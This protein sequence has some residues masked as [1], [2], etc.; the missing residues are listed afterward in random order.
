MEI[1][2]EAVTQLHQVKPVLS[3]P[4]VMPVVDNHKI[5]EAW[6]NFNELKMKL[7]EDSDFIILKGEKYAKKSAFRK[8]AFAF[9]ISCEIKREERVEL[10]DGYAYEI[11]MRSSSPSGRFMTSVASCHS[12]ERHFS[13]DSDVRAIAQTRATN[14]AVAD[15]IGWSAP[16]AEEMM[17]ELPE[18]DE[19]PTHEATPNNWFEKIISNPENRPVRTEEQIASRLLSSKQ[20]SLLI[21]LIGEKI[22]DPEERENQLAMV[23]SL[24]KGEAH[25]LISDMLTKKYN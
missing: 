13:K 10:D 1:Q 24:S 23:D 6:R 25:Q 20:R 22:H 5:L 14:R 18:P 19:R 9:G 11:T 17:T 3:S 16:S 21:S 15:L 12:N 8:L 4:L 7:L 2:N